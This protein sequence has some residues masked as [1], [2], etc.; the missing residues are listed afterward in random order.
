MTTCFSNYLSIKA[1]V[2]V[3]DILASSCDIKLSS[4][5]AMLCYGLSEEDIQTATT[6]EEIL[7]SFWE[8]TF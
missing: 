8:I 7:L 2:T 3:C 1:P 6:S 4:L 5:F